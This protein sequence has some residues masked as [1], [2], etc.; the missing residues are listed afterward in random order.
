MKRTTV[1]I[2]EPL[3]QELKE[4]ARK[5]EEPVAALVRDALETYVARQRR[6][7]DGKLSFLGAGHS[8][9]SDIAERHEEILFGRRSKRRPSAGQSR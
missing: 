2:D 3:E 6:R 1:F 5:R 9:Q 4:I 8:G 7:R